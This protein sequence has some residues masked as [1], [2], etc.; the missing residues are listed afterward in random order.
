MNGA[1]LKKFVGDKNNGM[2]QICLFLIL[3]IFL[4]SCER[5]VES[6]NTLNKSVQL[7]R[8]LAEKLVELPLACVL[9]EYPNRLGQ[10]LGAEDDLA[11]PKQLR[12][13][14]YG[15]FDWHSAVHGHWSLVKLLRL[16]H[17]LEKT[18]QIKEV[19]VQ[20]LSSENIQTELEFF[21]TEHNRN[22]E[23]TYG[24]TWLLKL[25]QEL[26]LWE[27]PLG[28]ELAQNLEP[29][30]QHIEK[31]YLTFLPK[32]QYPIRT[33]DHPNTAFGLSFAHDYAVFAENDSL[34]LM[35]EKR[36]KDFYLSDKGCPMEWE[37]SGYDFLS[38][39][40]EE[41]GL[42]IR[43]LPEEDFDRWLGNFMPDILNPN[44]SLEPGRV[45]DRADGTLVHLDGLNFS[46]AWNL[47]LLAERYPE[48]DHLQKLAEEHINYSLDQISD[49]N[50]EGTHWLGT[51]A[52]K[53][54][55]DAN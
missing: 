9:T 42:M 1:R 45:G 31:S 33:G 35:I 51:F 2:K 47:Y 17:D 27:D 13:A 54:L 19:L 39:C 26:K 5:K 32:L 30:T 20:H 43:V 49:E 50:Y 46:R 53:A 16:Y 23:R 55:E 18:D 6:D 7:D 52:L 12:P 48:K 4:I 14:F 29:L 21:K 37:P 3:T 24:W 41:V 11:T 34:K 8:E 44:F 15:C 25:S 40:L 10:T 36:A 38:P 28:L 22:F